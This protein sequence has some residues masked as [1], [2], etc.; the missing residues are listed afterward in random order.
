MNGYLAR[1]LALKGYS[2]AVIQDLSNVA[3]R[4]ASRL[5]TALMAMSPGDVEQ[6]NRLTPGG[7]A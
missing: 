3:P 5:A 7:Q 6:I 1:D 2:R 4:D